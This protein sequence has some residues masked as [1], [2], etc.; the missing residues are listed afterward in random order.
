MNKLRARFAA[1]ALFDRSTIAK[2]RYLSCCSFRSF[3]LNKVPRSSSDNSKL[4]DKSNKRTPLSVVVRT[5][6]VF[7]SRTSTM[8][9]FAGAD[10]VHCVVCFDG[11][12]C[13]TTVHS[14][15]VSAHACVSSERSFF[16]FFGQP[17]F[18]YPLSESVTIRWASLQKRKT[19][20]LQ[21]QG[22]WAHS[23]EIAVW[24]E[25]VRSKPM[26]RG[27]HTA[28]RR[29]PRSR[30]GGGWGLQLGRPPGS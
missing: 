11:T 10:A 30:A 19:I 9:P 2:A 27:W 23:E 17:S 22:T 24:D 20:L 5:S 26:P 15:T 28:S 13:P 4:Y 21:R 12:G 29:S 3:A 14:R 6:T 8:T 18:M 7:L 1:R 25:E 16:F